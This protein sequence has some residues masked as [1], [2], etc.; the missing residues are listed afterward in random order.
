MFKVQKALRAPGLRSACAVACGVLLSGLW[1]PRVAWAEDLL[2]PLVVTATRVPTRVSRVT[3]DVTVIERR[4]IEAMA[5]GSLGDL[6]ATVPGLQVSSSGGLGKTST[7]SI[8]GGDAKQVVLVIDGVRYGS[9]TLGQPTFDN[10][11]LL[12]I[13]R[14]EV[15]RGPL[16][17]LY[18][19]DA[20]SG[21]IQVFTRQ[22]QPGWHPRASVTVGSQGYKDVSAGLHGGADALSYSLQASGQTTDGFSATNARSGY[23]YNADRDGYRQH[24][25]SA[26]ASLKLGP[27]WQAQGSVMRVDGKNWFDDG[28]AATSPEPNTSSLMT[29]SVVGLSLK[30]QIKPAWLTQFR[31]G[32]TEDVSDTREAVQDNYIARIAT[33]QTQMFW[34]NTFDVGL[35]QVLATLE[36]TEQS[37]SNSGVSYDATTRSLD[38]LVLAWSGS[39]GDH[40]WQVAA[41]RDQNSQFGQE[42]TGTVAYGYHLAQGWRLGGNMGT[43]F[44]APSFNQLYWPGYGKPGLQPQHGFARELNLAWTGDGASAKVVR[45]DN[46]IRDFIETGKTTVS[47]IDGVRLSGWTLSGQLSQELGDARVYADGSLDWLDAH[48]MATQR[49]LVRRAKRVGQAKVGCA[50]GAFD[51]QVSVRGN[52]GAADHNDQFELDHLPG[53]GIWGAQLSYRVAPDWRVALRAE[54]LGNRVYETAWGYNQAGRQAFLTLS[55]NPVGN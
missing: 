3:A 22:G 46:R 11:P 2:D 31:L 47:N 42:D 21:V 40:D 32:Q 6:L 20:A 51:G 37:V 38:A 54:N 48:D 9:A 13:E 39:E 19:A 27:T 14:I 55:Y 28:Q 52:S 16:A 24:S 26:N 23:Y 43:S 4:A 29:T 53:F 7:V 50:M 44:V 41:R 45:F 25:L 1:A 5:G 36:H 30:G 10:L 15:V 18:G 17:S 33:R 49:P 35:G 8:R 34:E 12:L